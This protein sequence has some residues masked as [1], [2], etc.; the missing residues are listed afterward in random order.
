M[1]FTMVMV[2]IDLH[3][4]FFTII[5]SNEFFKSQIKI[6]TAPHP[7]GGMGIIPGPIIDI[8]ILIFECFQYSLS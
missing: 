8:F 4:F 5:T 6:S 7:V 2:S 3:H 1:L